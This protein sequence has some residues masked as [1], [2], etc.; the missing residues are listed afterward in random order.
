MNEIG[1]SGKTSL[2]RCHRSWAKQGLRE[3]HS[4]ERPAN[5]ETLMEV[6]ACYNPY[7]F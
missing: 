2:R 3:E 5:A 1:W 6:Q 7:L 4:R